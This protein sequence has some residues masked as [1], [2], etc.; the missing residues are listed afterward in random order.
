MNNIYS[1]MK[2]VKVVKSIIVL[3]I[4]CLIEIS[5]AFTWGHGVKTK[6][7]HIIFIMADDLV[8][9]IDYLFNFIN[10][11]ICIFY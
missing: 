10:L 5:M 8:R 11:I 3:T 6:K 7:P 1:K 9:F 2:S 4:L